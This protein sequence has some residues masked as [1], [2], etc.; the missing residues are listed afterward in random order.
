M[1]WALLL[2]CGSDAGPA[3]PGSRSAVLAQRAGGLQRDAQA[4]ASGA[5]DIEGWMDEWREASPEDRPGI[6]ARIAAR[7]MELQAQANDI[8]AR[9]VAIEEGARAWSP[10]PE[11]AGQMPPLDGPPA[12]PPAQS[13]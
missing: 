4:I 7:A 10:P 1:L 3:A 9:V 2:A 13:P 12:V 6:E 5:T 11:A 8:Q